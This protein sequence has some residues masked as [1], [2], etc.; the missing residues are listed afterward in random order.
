MESQV[1]QAM[2]W[3]C[4]TCRPVDIPHHLCRSLEAAVK[5]AAKFLN[6]AVKP[7][8][9]GGVKLKPWGAQ[10]A[11]LELADA[12][13]YPVAIQPHAKG[14]FPESHERF[15]GEILVDQHCPDQT[16]TCFCTPVDLLIM[17]CLLLHWA[18][19]VSN[20]SGITSRSNP[21]QHGTADTRGM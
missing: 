3:L 10:D 4:G 11:F 16:V 20:F 2:I 7:V 12:S 18:T 19:R 14:L 21:F 5:A 8:L 15:I 1:T 6:N 13:G 17:A 9:V